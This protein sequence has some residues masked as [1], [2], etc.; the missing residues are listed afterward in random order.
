M[1]LPQRPAKKLEAVCAKTLDANHHDDD[2]KNGDR[3]MGI[4]VEDKNK[5]TETVDGP[6]TPRPVRLAEDA[7]RRGDLKARTLG[8]DMAQ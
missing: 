4:S 2:C 3:K 7:W 1:E 6:N 5:L 8:H